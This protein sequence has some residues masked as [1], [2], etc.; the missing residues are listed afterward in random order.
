MEGE[1]RGMKEFQSLS[2][3]WKTAGRTLGSH[4]Y[5]VEAIANRLMEKR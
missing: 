5:L 3:S 1:K 4:W 2:D